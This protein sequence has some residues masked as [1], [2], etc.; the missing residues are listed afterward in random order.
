[1]ADRQVGEARDEREAAE[2]HEAAAPEAGEREAGEAAPLL[3]FGPRSLDYDLGPEHPLSPRRFGPGIELLEAVGARPGPTPEPAADEVLEW[4]HDRAYVELVR[5]FSRQPLGPPRAGI[6]P[7]DTPAFAGMHEAAA[8]V[9]GGSVAAI[10][11]ILR[12]DAVHA[13][14]PGGGL[15]HAMPDRAS[16]FCV[17]DDPALAIARARRD[18]LRVLY[19]DFDVHHGD[20]VQA[21]HWDDPD[22]LTV[23]FHETG[24]SLFPGTGFVAERGGPN[25]PGSAVNVP[26]DPG[27]GERGW[28]AA[29]ERV[30]PALADEFRPDL[31]VSQHGSDGHALDPLAHLEL[32]TTAMGAAARLTDAIAHRWAGGRWL[33]TGGGGYD[34]YR[35]VP[36]AWAL[37]WLAMAHAPVPDETP[38]RWRERWAADAARHGQSPPPAT[39]EDPPNL[40]RPF[41]P[42]DAALDARAVQSAEAALARHRTAAAGR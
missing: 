40:G 14:H 20:G 16:G 15:H 2:A 32:T 26:V 10:D 36:R 41:E 24:R 22:V 7:G 29:V 3:V 34:V 6:G 12:G 5:S 25:A 13:F 27:T 18:G 19:L 11:A 33:A 21:I 17:Y 4:V 1:M 37:V 28:L 31:V 35:V 42:F 8:S 38:L 30:A 9:A 39:F 23:S